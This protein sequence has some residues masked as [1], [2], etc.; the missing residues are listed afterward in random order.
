MAPKREELKFSHIAGSS[1]TLQ[2]SLAISEKVKHTFT[3]WSGIPF[4]DRNQ[5]KEDICEYKHMYT[6]V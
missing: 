6:N 2:K 3:V 5:E 4:I 1:T